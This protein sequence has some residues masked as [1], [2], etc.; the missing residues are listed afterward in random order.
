M[1]KAL[2]YDDNK[3]RFDLLHP[4]AQ[5][6]LVRVLTKGAQKYEPRNWERGMSW[7]KVIASLKRHLNA[8]EQ[9]IDIDPETGELHI[10]HLQC[11]VHF[12]SAYYKIY[13]QGDDRQQ[14]FK[15]PFKKV[16]LDIDGVL[17]DFEKAFLELF[18][19]TDYKIT[20]WDDW[21]FR[22]NFNETIQNKEFWQTISPI[23]KPEE[24]KYPISG[25]VTARPIEDQITQAWLNLFGFPK[26]ELINVGMDQSK[27]QVLRDKKCN[28]FVDDSIKNFIECQS[29]EILCYL[30]TRPHNEKYDVGHYRVNNFQEFLNKL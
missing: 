15:K 20:D 6:G 23:I 25:Y 8:F 13:P 17:A 16:Y 30:M 9:G 11:N 12:L 5:E 29:N 2:R 14:W 22:D 28:V 10:D 26:V 24:I 27:L 4:I 18:N 1:E 3:L 19:V 7:S 21:L